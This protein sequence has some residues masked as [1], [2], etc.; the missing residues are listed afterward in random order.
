MRSAFFSCSLPLSKAPG[1]MKSWSTNRFPSHYSQTQILH[2]LKARQRSKL[3][4]LQRMLKSNTFCHL[5]LPMPFLH[6]LSKALVKRPLL[7][8]KH[9][10]TTGLEPF[11]TTEHCLQKKMCYM[12]LE[13]TTIMLLLPPSR[14]P[15]SK[16]CTAI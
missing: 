6:H 14:V 9:P 11:S 3:E 12:K 1:T 7:E 15:S 2:R 16:H 13:C 8:S 5:L 10:P 4:Q